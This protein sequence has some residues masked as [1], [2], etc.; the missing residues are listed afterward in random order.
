VEKK[1][2]CLL[3]DEDQNLIKRFKKSV[4]ESKDKCVIP[5]KLQFRSITFDHNAMTM[6]MPQ[7]TPAVLSNNIDTSSGYALS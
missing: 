4:N 6:N 1:R 5:Q 3:S 2:K 7:I